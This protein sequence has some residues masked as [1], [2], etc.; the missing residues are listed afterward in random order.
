MVGFVLPLVGSV[1]LVQYLSWRNEEQAVEQL[2]MQLQERVNDRIEERLRHYSEAPPKVTNLLKQALQRG[3]LDVNNLEAWG[4]YLFD[5]GRVFNSFPFLYFGNQ[6]GDYVMLRQESRKTDQVTFGEG[7]SPTLVKHLNRDPRQAAQVK[8]IEKYDPRTRPW[9]RQAATGQT[10][11]TD[12]Y[13]FINPINALGNTFSRPY[14]DQDGKTLLGVI[15]ADF[16]LIDIN[17][18]MTNLKISES[19]EAFILDRDGKL[20][21]SSDKNATLKPEY[22]PRQISETDN[23]LIQKTSQSLEQQFQNFKSINTSQ[24]FSFQQDGERQLAQVRPFSDRYGL[25]WLVVVVVPESDFTGPIRANARLTLLLT[26]GV[27]GLA[28][29]FVVAMAQKISSA[30]RRLTEASQEIAQGNLKQTVTGSS[31]QELHTMARAFTDMSQELQ[32]SYAQLEDYSLS[33]ESKVKE[34]TQELEQ[35]IC[36]RKQAQKVI[37]H[38]AAMDNLLTQIS[39]TLLDQ[40][41]DTA[42][43]FAL[44]QIGEFLDCERSCIFRFYDPNQFGMTHEWCAEGIPSYFEKRQRMKGEDFSWFAEQ[45]LKGEPFQI[46]NVA[47]MPPEAAAE[48]AEYERQSIKSI[49]NVPMIH[50]DRVVGFIGLDTIHTARSWRADDITV[51]RRVGQM[52]A[53]AQS[54]HEAEVELK[55]A[56]ETAEVANKA[57]SEFLANMSHE[58]RSPLNAILGFAQLM[59]RSN[60]LSTEHKDNVGIINRSGEHLL[61]LINDV[62]DMSKIEAGRTVLSPIDFDLHHLIDDLR[63]LFQLQAEQKQLYLNVD[64]GSD[65]PQYVHT[66]QGKLRQVL[67]NL[68]SNAMKFTQEGGITLQV[69]RESGRIEEDGLETAT[70]HFEIAD[71][72]AGIASDELEQ[73]FEPFVQTQAGHMSQGGTGLGLPISRQFVQLM[74]GELSLSSCQSEGIAPSTVL[75]SSQ[76][77]LPT[78]GTVAAFDIQVH[79]AETAQTQ[80]RERRILALAS[81][82]P[83]YRI[84]IVDDKSDNRKLLVKLLSPL[85]FELREATNGQ[86][87]V[88]LWQ[89]WQ[90]HLIW[91]DLRMPVMDG[92]EATQQIRTAQSEDAPPPKIIALSASI[93][94]EEQQLAFTVGCDDFMHK[95]FDDADL[96]ATMHEHIGVRYIY[97]DELHDNGIIFEAQADRQAIL[98]ISLAA[99]PPKLLSDLE[100]ATHRLHWHRLQELTATIALQDPVLADSLTQSVHNFNYSQILEAIQ[101]ARE[102]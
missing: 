22:Q 21:G 69:Q 35:E 39:R 43:G 76:G 55:A 36:D 6:A 34:R 73:V 91:M 48:K 54:R 23:A 28:I 3:E 75:N 89:Q 33:L 74:G 92:L 52:V 97:D 85:G 60:T 82:Q 64:Y 100:S 17:R 45:L 29:L 5:Q 81:G 25:D 84:L 67:I 32:T 53:M 9:Y 58:L 63:G 68:L 62:L 37:Q 93:L 72:G 2:V 30:M 41:I 47:E 49:L 83:S 44:R 94:K 50:A 79:I 70:L 102:D 57:K 71:T 12:I 13:E 8:E 61:G 86:E 56:K 88:H 59:N 16:T 31:I 15:A 77:G 78:Q 66:D 51:L 96:F 1:V 4:P 87:A 40:D 11:W 98:D 38:R 90:P 46:P 24:S 19:G 101:A 27:L 7:K 80:D 95:P 10:K 14:Y 20:I 18:F 99:L 65:L 26:L 42:I